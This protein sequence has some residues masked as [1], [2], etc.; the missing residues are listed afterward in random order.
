MLTRIRKALGNSSAASI[1]SALPVA[2]LG[3]V[4][5]EMGDDLAAKFEAELTQVGGGTYRAK[6]V[7]ELQQ[8]IASI[9][10]S[11]VTDPAT[12]VTCGQTVVLSR[13]RLLQQLGIA[14]SLRRLSR[15]VST[16]PLSDSRL[17]ESAEL[18]RPPANEAATERQGFKEECFAAMA[19][20]T[21]VDFA[22]A[23][24][25]T[26]VLS[27]ATEGS[28]LTS[29]APPVHIALYRR[30]QLVGSLE[31][32]LERAVDAGNLGVLGGGRSIVL[33]TGTSRTA[34]IEQILIR[35][36]HG[37]RQIHAIL[38]ENSCFST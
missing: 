1:F 29:L 21:G 2:D 34:D 27:S 15:I 25:G 22:L 9:L 36:V 10:D 20:I 33:V 19:G 30:E 12:D 24:S 31:D 28:Q 32:V 17:S 6:T 18:P 23:E 35:G 26:L 37:P 38:V 7:G 13:N 11:S 8:V 14:E 4:M 16:W 3:A 5:P